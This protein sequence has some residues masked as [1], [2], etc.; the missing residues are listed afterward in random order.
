MKNKLNLQ[1]K[2]SIPQQ[3]KMSEKENIIIQSQTLPDAKEEISQIDVELGHMKEE[4]EFCYQM[5][6]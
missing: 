6:R 2:K 3:Q 5:K 1:Q 4:K